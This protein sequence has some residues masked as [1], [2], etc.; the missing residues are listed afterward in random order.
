MNLNVFF[1]IISK[2]YIKFSNR[3]NDWFYLPI[4]ILS[5][6][7]SI[8][9]LTLSMLFIKVHL[10]IMIFF[11][12]L[13]FFVLI[14]YYKKFKDNKLLVINYKLSKWNYIFTL[15]FLIVDFLFLFY[16]LK[17]VRSLNMVN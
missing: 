15:M 10:A 6:L 2:L 17:Y 3:E 9:I 11:V 1:V 14:I 7:I 5:F 8:N 4:L 13:L 12:F 16:M